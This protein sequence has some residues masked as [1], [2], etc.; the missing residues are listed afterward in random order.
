[1]TEQYTAGKPRAAGGRKN[2]GSI[3]L[4]ALGV[5]D[6]DFFSLWVQKDHLGLSFTMTEFPVTIG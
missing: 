1:M 3:E 6:C 4:Y 2:T 5:R